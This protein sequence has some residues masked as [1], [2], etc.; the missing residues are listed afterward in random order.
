MNNVLGIVYSNAY[1]SAV[2]ELTNRR[3]MGSIPFGGRY[4]LIDFAL[5]NMVNGGIGK[6]GVITK[7]N[8]QSLMDH[9]GT[10]KPWDLARKREGMFILPPFFTGEAGMYSN[11]I[12]ALKGSMNF[13]SR[14]SEEFVL[15]CD[16]NVVCNIDVDKLAR[17]HIKN[18]A[19]I[20]VLYNTGK[21]PQLSDIM[22][23][24]LG[25]DGRVEGVAVGNGD[26]GESNYS[27][28]YF[29]MRR[30]LLMRLINEAS[31]MHYEN[32]ER[33]IIQ[34]NVKS[35]HIF[36]CKVNG[37]AGTVD[38]LKSYY[39]INLELLDSEKRR[40]LFTP[41]RPVYTKV[42]DDMPAIYGLGSDVE[43]SLVSDGCIID[44]EVVNCVLARGVRIEKGAVVRNSIIMQDSFIGSGAK[45]ESVILDKSVVIRP[46][47][48]VCGTDTFP[49]YVSKGIMV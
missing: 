18:S 28:N 23:L 21:A 43:N 27:L 14:S 7:S 46:N 19:S 31:A 29:F 5:S 32:F 35:L 34:R 1:D 9:L 8:Y 17:E 48:S 37:F 33:D 44:G 24:S 26:T 22:T 20:T 36:G 15:L 12:E 38:S 42:R 47:K 30:A 13:I 16:C 10:G 11:R 39:E 45:L 49:V 25:P 3:T 2:P 6:V 4:R 40:E 41:E